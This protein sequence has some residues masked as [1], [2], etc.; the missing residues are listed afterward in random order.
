MWTKSAPSISDVT[1]LHTV[2]RLGD[3]E[4]R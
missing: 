1:K 3:R 4:A 2:G